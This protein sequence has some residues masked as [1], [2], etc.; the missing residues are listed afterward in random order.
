MVMPALLGDS[1]MVFGAHLDLGLNALKYNRD[2]R[3]R[4]PK[5]KPR[6]LV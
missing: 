1:P 5:C 6:K 4:L 3:G 2:L